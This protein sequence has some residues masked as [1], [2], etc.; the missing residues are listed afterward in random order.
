VLATRVI[1]AVTK[2]NSPGEVIG[3]DDGKKAHETQEEV[4][5][6]P[7]NRPAQYT[8]RPKYP[9]WQWALFWFT[10]VALFWLLS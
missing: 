1:R 3:R 7:E 9:L 10:A 5:T 6:V 2:F 8:L 4:G